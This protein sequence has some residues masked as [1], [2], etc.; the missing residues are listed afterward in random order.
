M[1]A[2]TLKLTSV[3][4]RSAP[5][6]AGWAAT[7]FAAV[8]EAGASLVDRYTAQRRRA[9][10]LRAMQEMFRLADSYASSQP[11]FASDLRAAATRVSEGY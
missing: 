6:G 4:V 1:A 5:R 2:T 11:G 3:P 9:A 10:E 7:A 8:L